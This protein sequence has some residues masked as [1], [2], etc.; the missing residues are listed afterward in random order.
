MA[1]TAQRTDPFAAFRFTVE[2]G[3]LSVAGFSACSGMKLTTPMQAYAEGGLNS[4][5]HQLPSATQQGN[6]V[7]KRGL[8]DRSLWDWYARLIDGNVEPKTGVIVINDPSGSELSAEW[9]FSQALPTSWEGPSLD[10]S[11]SAVAV[12]TITLAHEGLRRIH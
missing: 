12:E 10:A 8:V 1:E 2:L 4:H 6:I 5:Q 7:L 3:D 11:Q 9:E